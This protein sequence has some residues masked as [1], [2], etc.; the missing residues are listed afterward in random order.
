MASV[1]AL[2][3]LRL[4]NANI[5]EIVAISA[6]NVQALVRLLAP[7]RLQPLALPPVRELKQ[8]AQEP[9][10][11]VQQGRLAQRLVHRIPIKEQKMLQTF[12]FLAFFIMINMLIEKSQIKVHNVP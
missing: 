10:E 2:F 3:T 12:R 8:P 11:R 4:R 6:A 5:A 9:R 1:P 7:A